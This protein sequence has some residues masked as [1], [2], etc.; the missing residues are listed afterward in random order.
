MATTHPWYRP[1]RYLH[2]DPPVGSKSA[3]KVATNSSKVAS[4]SFYPLISYHVTSKKLKR[5]KSTGKLIPKIKNRP[6]SYAAHMDS[7]IY[8]YYAWMLSES[9]EKSLKSKGINECVLA[10]RSLGKSNIDFAFDAFNEIRNR[11]NCS[12]VALDISGFFDNLD[13]EL[14][15]SSW[16][17][18]IDKEKLPDDHFSVFRSL[19]KFS[20]VDKEKLYS[21]L[22][23]S[24]NNPKKDRY[25]VCEPQI[26]RDIVRGKGLVER[27]A[28]QKGI[29]QG[30]PIS[31]LLSNI[32][33]TNFDVWANDTVKKVGG[34]Y[35]RYCDDMLFILPRSH[36]KS[37]AGLARD[38]IKNLRID[39]NT[40]KTEIRDFRLIDGVI[41]ADKPL[42]YL[43]FTYDGQRILI[44]SAALARYSEKMKRG[45]KLAKATMRKRNKLRIGRGDE[46]KELFRKKVYEQ[47]SHL[48]KRNFIR[49]GL[50]SAEIMKSKSMKRQL[51]PLWDRLIREI[52]T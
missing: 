37:I 21:A 50:R 26:F 7:H 1:R 17:S 9:Y 19:T 31:A 29:P 20:T 40:D 6:I 46:P 39:I 2:F 25:R 52:E 41:T 28:I 24:L 13:H 22:N 44:R 38:H 36:K 16:L 47:Y 34:K 30:T 42:Q 5:D 33:M 27:H 10:F 48:G 32:Y 35:F 12:A 3:T 8:S 43:G 51:K 14:L 15:K 4:H 18:L 49:Y 23:I 11:K 45:V